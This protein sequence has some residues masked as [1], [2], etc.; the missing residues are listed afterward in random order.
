MSKGKEA[1]HSL[2]GEKILNRGSSKNKDSKVRRCLLLFKESLQ[3]SVVRAEGR[4]RVVGEV[5][6]QGEGQGLT[7]TE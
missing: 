3:A 4:G 6:G 5:R 1:R 7:T 2:S